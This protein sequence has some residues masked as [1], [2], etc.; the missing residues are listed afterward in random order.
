MLLVKEVNP[1]K[2]SLDAMQAIFIFNK[3]SM[4]KQTGSY[5]RY[6]Y[7]VYFSRIPSV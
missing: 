4:I 1:E 5:C 3:S 6:F 7:H 2:M